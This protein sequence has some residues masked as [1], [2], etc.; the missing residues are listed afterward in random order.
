MLSLW[1]TKELKMNK[2]GVMKSYCRNRGRESHREE[3]MRR[4]VEDLT[5]QTK[6]HTT[7]GPWIHL[8]YST[9]SDICVT[10]VL[11]PKLIQQ[12]SMKKLK[13]NQIFGKN[14]HW[15]TLRM[16]SFLFYLLIICY[17]WEGIWQYQVNIKDIVHQCAGMSGCVNGYMTTTVSLEKKLIKQ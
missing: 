1:C 14:L 17:I 8:K 10:A 11:T 5:A 4:R 16:W 15:G 2:P 13:S 3:G 9:C 6:S 12:T 7:L